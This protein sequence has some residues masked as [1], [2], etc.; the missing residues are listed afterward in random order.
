MQ[1]LERRSAVVQADPTLPLTVDKVE[2]FARGR[3]QVGDNEVDP[4]G[5]ASNGSVESTG[6]QL[7]I[8]SELIRHPICAVFI[9]ATGS[10]VIKN[11]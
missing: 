7:R 8:C 11:R 5:L 6:P 1:I 4:I 2:T 3:S 9:S 10:G